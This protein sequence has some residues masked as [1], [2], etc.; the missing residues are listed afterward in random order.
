MTPAGKQRLDLLLV[1]RGLAESRE[2]AR[3][4]VLAGQVLVD[5][6]RAAKPGHSV[7]LESCVEILAR[8]PYVSR[9][10][11]KLEAA[12]IAFGSMSPEDLP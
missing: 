2:K 9:A 7:P 3:A 12:L 1:D 5:G 8:L 6:M 10:G 4:L 11:R